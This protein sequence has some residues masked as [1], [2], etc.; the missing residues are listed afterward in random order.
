MTERRISAKQLAKKWARQDSDILPVRGPAA[1]RIQAQIQFGYIF[2]SFQ[3][4]LSI[5]RKR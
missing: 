2:V 3:E 4:Q 1:K 5:Y